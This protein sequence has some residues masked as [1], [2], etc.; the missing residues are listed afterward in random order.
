MSSCF[1]QPCTRQ[2]SRQS[3]N[4][5]NFL[6]LDFNYV[7]E[8]FILV[9]KVC[10]QCGNKEWNKRNRC[11][12]CARIYRR[13]WRQNNPEKTKEASRRWKQ[14]NPERQKELTYRWQQNNPERRRELERRW[15]QNNPEKCRIKDCLRRAQKAN[16]KSEPY[17]FQSICNHYG[18][19]CLACKRT[20]LLLT[21]DHIIPLSHGGNDVAS[22]IQPLCGPC[23]SSKGNHHQ[24]DYRPDQSPPHP[25]QLSFWRK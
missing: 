24:T 3:P 15:R 19:K 13:R 22:N 4:G 25:K 7:I 23:N 1:S 2:A 6:F 12:F 8:V 14:H 20:D 18:N 10:K 21:P 9:T 11:S 16:T 5:G 17:N